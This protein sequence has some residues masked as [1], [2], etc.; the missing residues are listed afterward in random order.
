MKTYDKFINE[1]TVKDFDGEEWTK[2]I[3]FDQLVT[4][5][6]LDKIKVA[7]RN[8]NGYNK[9]NIN[10][11]MSLAC[12]SGNLESVKYFFEKGAD[13]HYQDDC[14]LYEACVNNHIEIMKYLIENGAD[15]NSDK[16]RCLSH[17]GTNGNLDITVLLVENGADISQEDYFI[18][19]LADYYKKTKIV[20]YL[21]EYVLNNNP[22]DI[23]KIIEYI[24]PYMKK[25]YPWLFA[26]LDHGLI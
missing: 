6:D 11:Y 8:S 9:D 25:F 18:I 2:M 24:P 22:Q 4:N 7:V 17:A 12:K 14:C 1:Q 5:G 21:C 3:K 15:V 26:G 20:D 19:Y 10:F 13:V 16:N 23:K